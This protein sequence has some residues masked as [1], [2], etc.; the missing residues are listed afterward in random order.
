MTRYD[1]MQGHKG[2]DK[3]FWNKVG[4]LFKGD[5]GKMWIELQALPISDS[6]GRVRMQVFEPRQQSDSNRPERQ[7]RDSGA[8]GSYAA[9]DDDIPF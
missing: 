6:E 3:T 8:G 9:M 2:R 5:D 1:L 4:S 7:D